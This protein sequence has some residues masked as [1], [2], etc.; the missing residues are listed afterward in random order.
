MDP[1][2][3]IADMRNYAAKSVSLVIADNGIYKHD[4]QTRDK[5][6]ECG[7][8]LLDVTGKRGKMLVCPDRECGYR[9]GV[10]MTSNARC[11]ECHKKMEMR[12]DGENKSFYCTCGYREK[13]E[14]FN[15]RVGERVNK[16]EVS[17]FLQKQNEPDPIN[18]SLA[19]ALA[20]WKK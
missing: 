5:C 7:K 10:S 18:S 3:F 6:P 20:K 9:K 14:T 4:N 2:K 13:L 15:Q 11:P 17:Q 19:D 8:F 12:G 16:K 1:A